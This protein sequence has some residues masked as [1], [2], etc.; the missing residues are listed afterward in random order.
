MGS[1]QPDQSL[2]SVFT[3]RKS[4]S[5]DQSDLFATSCS[6]GFGGHPFPAPGDSNGP[7]SFLLMGSDLSG[8]RTSRFPALV[9]AVPW[10]IG[11]M[12]LRVPASVF[13]I[14]IRRAS[15]TGA[16]HVQVGHRF[17]EGLWALAGGHVGRRERGTEEA[18][19]HG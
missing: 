5:P 2:A 12:K 1:A 14:R 17:R 18:G 4:C 11:R 7:V 8:L 19:L 16:A 10:A 3:C 13:S 9:Q 15:E 6:P